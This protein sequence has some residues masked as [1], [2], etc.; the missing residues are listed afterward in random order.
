MFH[1]SQLRAYKGF[2]DNILHLCYSKTIRL[3]STMPQEVN[4]A[5]NNRDELVLNVAEACKLLKLSRGAIY[6]GIRCGQIP[7]IRIGR[8]L[9]IP[10]VA[11]QKLLDGKFI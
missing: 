2:V 8:R 11:L 1:K 9:L 10:L 6:S 5:K 3:D 7:A 4:M